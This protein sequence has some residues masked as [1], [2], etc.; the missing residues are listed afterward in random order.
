MKKYYNNNIIVLTH[1]QAEYIYRSFKGFQVE[2]I[3]IPKLLED[4]FIE[5]CHRMQYKT[6]YDFVKDNNIELI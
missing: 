5:K 6:F 1:E 3:E 4:Y 2:K